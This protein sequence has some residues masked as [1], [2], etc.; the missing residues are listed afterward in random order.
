MTD[1]SDASP[2]PQAPF[3]P[4]STWAG[5]RALMASDLRRACEH[6]NNDSLV[7]RVFSFLL[8]TYQ[9]L[10]WHRIARCLYLKGWRRSARLVFMFSLYLTR[11]EIPPTS[12]LGPEALVGHASG[13]VF[14]AK[15]GRRISLYGTCGAGGG[16]GEAD[17]G[18]GPGYP[19][20]GD[21]VEVGQL[22]AV[23]GPIRIGNNVRIGPG[24]VVTRDV[25]DGSVVVAAR[26]KVMRVEGADSAGAGGE[27]AAQPPAP[28]QPTAPTE[29][30]A[31]TAPLAAAAT[32][33]VAVAASVPAQAETDTTP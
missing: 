2:S 4:A 27:A 25:P 23:L 28:A 3:D 7:Q 9:V 16:L 30:P 12:S 11:Q 26:C 31:G 5:T 19:V 33:A 6:I 21:N 32:V 8:P 24:S 15:A 20:F 22:C 13:L 29:S 17:I 1:T 10:F 18:A 14:Y